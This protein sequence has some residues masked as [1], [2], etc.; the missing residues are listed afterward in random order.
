MTDEVDTGKHGGPGSSPAA[1][2]PRFLLVV[3]GLAGLAFAVQFVSGIQELIAP[4]FLAL[5]L[6]I[7][8][9]PVQRR[10]QAAR[11]PRFLAAM[12]TVLIVLVIIVGFFTITVWCLAELVLV[13][14]QYTEQLTEVW[15]DLLAL[16]LSWGVS[17]EYIADQL[18]NFDFSSLTGV[19]TSV[20]SNATSVVGL[21]TTAI[22]AVFFIAMDS[23]SFPQRV[24][25]TR[26]VRP[27][28]TAAM[29]SFADGVR[30][31]WVVATVFGLIVAV[32]D[33][34]AL[35][36]IGVPL[37]FVWG[38]LAFLTNYIPNVGFIVGL[39]PPALI[40][41]IDG[42]WID[43][44]WVVIAYCVLN[45]VIQSIIQPKF[46]GESVGVTPFISF[47]SLFFWT[48][49][50]GPLGAL[51]A[52]PSTL[53]VKAFLVDA[54][55]RATW[56]NNLIA[57]DLTTGSGLPVRGAIGFPSR[58]AVAVTGVHGTVPSADDGGEASAEAGADGTRV[59]GMH[60]PRRRDVVVPA[61]G[62]FPVVNERASES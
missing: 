47:L 34:V 10:L 44:L 15:N 50:L 57:S 56:V 27:E 46:T 39:V 16:V 9:Y 6:A 37:L 40:A 11:V 3:L 23:M 54:D 17:P 22:M 28:F 31:Y 5:N 48:W 42:G 43:A 41:L 8:A 7:V 4:V 14:P 26:R 13:M 61:T 36:I 32:L 12:V 59:P 30:R 35:A 20:L 45:F 51:L 25:M 58:Q 62:E 1:P 49:V 53:L 60:R 33:M 38:V 21:L 52:L 29:F 18:E 19:A 2:W 55:P 24:A